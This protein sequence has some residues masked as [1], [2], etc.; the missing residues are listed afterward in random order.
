VADELERQLRTFQTLVGTHP[1]HIDSHQHVHREQPVRSIL[2]AAAARLGIP[3]RD[4]SSTVQY[5]GDFYGQTGKGAPHPCAIT[6]QALVALIEALPPGF[7][8]LGCHPSEADDLNSMYR[9]ERVQELAVLCDSQV[10]AAIAAQ[11]IL[12]R[13]FHGLV[14][15]PG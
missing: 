10:S 7:T 5:R 6:V 12:L 4:A 11:G 13:S 8:E 15:R 2:E 3:L 9:A 1:T 14:V